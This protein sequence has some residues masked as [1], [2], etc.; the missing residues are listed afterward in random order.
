MLMVDWPA[1][2]PVCIMEAVSGAREGF[3]IGPLPLSY[4]SLGFS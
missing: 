3:T 4:R 2:L 1:S